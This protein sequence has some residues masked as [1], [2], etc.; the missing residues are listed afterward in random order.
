MPVSVVVSPP[1]PATRSGI[2]RAA[3]SVEAA[4]GAPPLSDQSLSHLGSGEV[5][6]LLARDGDHLV[7]YAQLDGDSLEIAADDGAV[8]PLLAA[9][10]EAAPGDL[11]V[12]SHGRRSRLVPVLSERGFDRARELHQLRRPLDDASPLPADPPLADDIVVRAFVPGID[13]DAWLALNAA[14]FAEHRE[15]GAWTSADL[16]ARM[17]EPWF[18]AAG[19]LLAERHGEL[20]GFHWTKVHADRA[21]EVYVLGISPQAQGLGLGY[22]LLIRGLRLL[23]RRG[24][25]YVL[26]YVDG[27]NPAA[28][29]L[30]ERAGFARFDL[31]VQWRKA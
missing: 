31:D 22:A 10:A 26:L 27:D 24:C 5:T 17:A 2:L 15:Q 20:L 25:P 19:F 1:D 3:A 18:D 6:H 30:Y 21:G 16:Q 11:L 28:L 9:A 13:D 12:W 23:A 8:I 7:G 14:A 29:R 4:D